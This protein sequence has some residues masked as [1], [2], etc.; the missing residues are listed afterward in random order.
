MCDLTDPRILET[1]TAIVEDEPTNWLILGY[2]DTRDVISL[3]SKGTEGLDEF[4]NHLS[5]EVLYGFVR[6]EDRFIL[7]TWVS[8]QVSGVRRAR[9]LVHSRSVASTLK[10]HHAQL[11]ASTLNDLSDTN[12]RTR[13]KLGDGNQ[14]SSRRSSA[15]LSQKRLSRRQSTQSPVP[16]TSP[17][18]PSDPVPT[19]AVDQ[20]AQED[21]FV[22]ANEN[23]VTPPVSNSSTRYVDEQQ[24]QAELAANEARQ[25]QLEEEQR[26]Q[27]LLIQQQQEAEERKR[28]EE[29]E[30]EAAAIAAQAAEAAAAAEKE[31][32][33]LAAEKATAQRLE[34][35][36]LL[37]EK[38]EAERL[39]EEK[40]MLQLRLLEAE[41]N[42]DIVL[43]GFVSVQPCTSPFWRR[44]YFTIKGKSMTFY[45]D[46][47]N[48]NPITVLDLNNVKRLSNVNIDVETFVPNAF[49]LETQQNGA[50][51]LFADNRKERDTI[52]TALQTVI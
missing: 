11:T 13:L 5:D 37:K 1:Y 30:R 18:V 12:I 36:R 46:E 35:E 15:S 21:E 31:A 49:V 29:Q 3:Y 25:R 20:L 38:M 17:T 16:P 43:S 50:Y 33:R 39:M 26:Q 51:Q 6:V 23:F 52:L 22:E 47:M 45:S 48:P 8:E 24:Q 7:I 44:R 34:E 9:A 42:K 4:R 27:Q 40:K 14:P 41:K 32:K 28:R 10:L 19:A 2:N